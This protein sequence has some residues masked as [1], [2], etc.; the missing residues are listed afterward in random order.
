MELAEEFRMIYRTGK[1]ETVRPHTSAN[2][3]RKNKRYCSK[4]TLAMTSN[5]YNHDVRNQPFY[6]YWGWGGDGKRFR[7]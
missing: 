7:A 2:G 5:L 3:R 1:S 4:S 6:F